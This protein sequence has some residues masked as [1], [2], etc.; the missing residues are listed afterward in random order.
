[1]DGEV[2]L[3]GSSNI[4]EGRVEICNENVWHGMCNNLWD[5]RDADVVCQQL[6]FAVPGKE[7]HRTM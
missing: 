2:R 5:T 7:K 6:G 1:M 4:Y 3:Q